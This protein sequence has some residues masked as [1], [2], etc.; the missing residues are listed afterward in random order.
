MA[1]RFSHRFI[2]Y[3]VEMNG[4]VGIDFKNV[5]EEDLFEAKMKALKITDSEG[6]YSIFFV[7]LL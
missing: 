5:E 7:C 1:L 6:V 3:C 2:N 4:Y